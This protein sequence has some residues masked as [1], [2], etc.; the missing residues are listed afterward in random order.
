[1]IATICYIVQEAIVIN[2]SSIIHLDRNAAARQSTT[3]IG[4]TDLASE[5]GAVCGDFCGAPSCEDFEPS[6]HR[7]VAVTAV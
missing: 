3:D 6:F 1:M 7:L 2:S 5:R 4:S